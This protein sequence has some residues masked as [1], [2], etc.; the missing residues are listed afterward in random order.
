MN[1]IKLQ[2]HWHFALALIIWVV[3]NPFFQKLGESIMGNQGKFIASAIMGGLLL[4]LIVMWLSFAFSKKDV[5]SEKKEIDEI[6]QEF[7]GSLN[8]EMT[9][10]KKV[11]QA[12]TIKKELFSFLDWFLMVASLVVAIFFL[13]PLYY[14][15]SKNVPLI[16]IAYS[17][18]IVIAGSYVFFKKFK[19]YKELNRMTKEFANSLNE[20]VST[21]KSVCETKED[22]GVQIVKKGNYFK[23]ILVGVVFLLVFGVMKF[24]G[25]EGIKMLFSNKTEDSEIVQNKELTIPEDN[26]QWK[27]FTST[28]GKFK[29]KFPTFP[30]YGTEEVDIPG[31]KSKAIYNQ[32]TSN[33]TDGTIYMAASMLFPSDADISK[34][35]NILEGSAN[36]YAQNV[37]GRI[38]AS[39]FLDFDKYKAMVYLISIKNGAS[40]IGGKNILTEDF[41]YILS[42]SYESQNDKNAK[43]TDFFN[44]FELMK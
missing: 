11:G 9:T 33:Q 1:N 2:K 3:A 13:L 42:T 4:V 6:N 43:Y 24:V 38:I 29:I 26:D 39:E 35:E 17:I 5:P 19:K 30:T 28:I 7:V 22:N 16:D 14:S 15:I 37:N 10:D 40:Y 31:L 34:P 12:Q 20:S 41:L 18:I 44:S 23:A 25:Q 32:Y 27:E 8:K 36:V 21:D